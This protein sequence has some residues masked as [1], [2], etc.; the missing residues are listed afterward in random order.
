ME[1]YKLVFKKKNLLSNSSDLILTG[2]DMIMNDAWE[3]RYSN[4][5]LLSHLTYL[6]LGREDMEGK[7]ALSSPEIKLN[8]WI[9]PL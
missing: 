3:Y 8:G 1:K 9:S 6:F 5:W 2:F 7:E 4:E